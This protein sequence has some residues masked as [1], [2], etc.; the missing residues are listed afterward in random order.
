MSVPPLPAW[1]RAC[2]G[3]RCGGEWG[4]AR[5]GARGERPRLRD[6]AG[7]AGGAGGARRL[8][9]LPRPPAARGERGSGEGEPEPRWAVRMVSGDGSVGT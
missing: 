8:P 5:G 7:A 6:G 1:G 3:G 9:R 2:A 4:G